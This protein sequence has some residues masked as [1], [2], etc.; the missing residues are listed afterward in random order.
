VWEAKAMNIIFLQSKGLNAGNLEYKEGMQR[1]MTR[2]GHN[3]LTWGIGHE[4]YDTPWPTTVQKFK[5]DVILCC[6]DYDRKK[7]VPNF[8]GVRCLKVFWSMD[9]HLAFAKHLQACNKQKVNLVLVA[10]DSMVDKF[11]GRHRDAVF[12]PNSFPAD[13]MDKSSALKEYDIGFCGHIVNRGQWLNEISKQ[14]PM[15]LDISVIGEAM[16]RSLNSYRIGWNRNISF[17]IN[18]RTFETLGAGTFLLTNET[19]RISDLFEDGKHLV[20]YH[21]IEDCI[22]KARYYLKH[23]AKREA[24]AAA[25]HDHAHAN[26]SYDAR[27]LEFIKLVEERV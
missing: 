9:S 14:I 20:Y 24:I 8:W 7:W 13:L 6:E 27:A 15:R 23:P 10:M 16:V 18:C 2:L 12:F 26:H 25:G 17:D 4:S 5:P 11:K 22:D 1:A 3:V 19:D 21:T